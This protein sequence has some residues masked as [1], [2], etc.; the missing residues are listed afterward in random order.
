MSTIKKRQSDKF[1]IINGEGSCAVLSVFPTESKLGL[2]AN[3]H[4]YNTFY[5]NEDNQ[6][7]SEGKCVTARYNEDGS[8]GLYFEKCFAD[9]QGQKFNINNDAYTI[10]DSSGNKCFT[11]DKEYGGIVLKDCISENQDQKFM[12]HNKE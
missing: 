3:C 10:T 1:V 7:V 12:I 8:A 11:V 5:Q 9:D 4:R 2:A 6:I